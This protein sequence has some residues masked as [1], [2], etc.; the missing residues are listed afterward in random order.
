[1]TISF[2]QI[3]SFINEHILF[4]IIPIDVIIVV[5]LAIVIVRYKKG[6]KGGKKNE[7]K[8]KNRA[9]RTTKKSR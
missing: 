8:G 9:S 2:K 1:M 3:F 4:F 7:R 6:L 5:L